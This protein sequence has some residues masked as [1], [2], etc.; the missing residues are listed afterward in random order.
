MKKTCWYFGLGLACFVAGL[1]CGA[2]F[3]A[4]GQASAQQR[5]GPGEVRSVPQD[6]IDSANKEYQ[7]L[8]EIRALLDAQQEQLLKIEANTAAVARQTQG[9]A[10]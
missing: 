8:I 4:S 10:R 2:F 5:F 7:V 6:F 3:W 9:G 1:G